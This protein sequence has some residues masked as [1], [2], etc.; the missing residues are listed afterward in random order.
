MT[1]QQSVPVR[2]VVEIGNELEVGLG[3]QFVAGVLGF[4]WLGSLAKTQKCSVYK[5]RRKLIAGRLQVT[6]V[7]AL[8]FLEAA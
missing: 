8:E 5:L 1:D 2:P 3:G 6:E 4:F 7:D